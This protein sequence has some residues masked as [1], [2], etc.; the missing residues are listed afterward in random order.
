MCNNINSKNIQKY[1]FGGEFYI[2]Y[3]NIFAH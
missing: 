2:N 1:L 3:M